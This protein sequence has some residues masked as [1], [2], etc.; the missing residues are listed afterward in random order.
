M[1]KEDSSRRTGRQ[2]QREI[3]RIEAMPDS[4]IDTRDIPEILDWRGAKRGLFYRPLKR[5]LTLRIDAD[6]VDWFKSRAPKGA[7]YQT[8]MNRALREYAER[9]GRMRRA[10]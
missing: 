9:H 3:A 6:V 7:G 10:G 4:R 1:K 2:Q 8:D 5:Q